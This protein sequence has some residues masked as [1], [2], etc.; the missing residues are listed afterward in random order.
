MA[1]LGAGVER[2][3]EELKALEPVAVEGGGKAA[4]KV[5]SSS[6]SSLVIGTKL[7]SRRPE[8]REGFS[9]AGVVNSDAYLHAPDFR[10]SERA[11]QDLMYTAERIRPGGELI[12]QTRNP[13]A[14]LYRNIRRFDLGRFCAGELKERKALGYPPFSRL[15]L[16][17]VE[18]GEMPEG[19]MNKTH[20]EVEVLGP[21]PALT[22]RGRRVWKILLKSRTR[23]ALRPALVR[24]LRKLGGA[25]VS[26]D[27]DP[28]SV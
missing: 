13:G 25:K 17:T 16:I 6:E 15:A 14:G 22:K 5:L 24:V 26:V 3:E 27:V 12:I 19:G 28:I 23:Q 21:A 9:L 10:S 7:L 4:L 20:H 1:P 18:S 11:F 2:I 8:L